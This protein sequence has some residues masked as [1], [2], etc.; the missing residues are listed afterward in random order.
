MSKEIIKNSEIPHHELV[1]FYD[2]VCENLK[3]EYD[4]NVLLRTENMRLH[5][6]L[7]DKD[8]LLNYVTE[9]VEKVISI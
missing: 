9:L 2:S 6:K 5:Q 8:K 3:I 7:V 4:R 1:N